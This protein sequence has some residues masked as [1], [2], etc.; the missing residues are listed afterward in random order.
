MAYE[1]KIQELED[2]YQLN[3]KISKALNTVRINSN[4]GFLDMG[5]IPQILG[6]FFDAEYC[7]IGYCSDNKYFIDSRQWIRCIER[8]RSERM[9]FLSGNEVTKIPIKGSLIGSI[10]SHAKYK[11]N[12]YAGSYEYLLN[13]LGF[14]MLNTN[15]YK[16]ALPTAQKKHLIVLGLYSHDFEGNRRLIGY[17]QL[18][19]KLFKLKVPNEIDITG[20]NEN[21]LT[22]LKTVT[23][24][25]EL[26]LDN[27]LKNE[28]LSDISKDEDFI[29]ELI[30]NDIN[31]PEL[32]YKKLL[33]HLTSEYSFA[34]ASFWF[35][36]WNGYE[37]SLVE[38]KKNR[39]DL[40]EKKNINHLNIILRSL[41]LNDNL[42]SDIPTD[43]LRKILK[44][45][46][47]VE[48][49][50]QHIFGERIVEEFI[51]NAN[52]DRRF[53]SF[54]I[55]NDED[56]VWYEYEKYIKADSAILI[57]IYR[58]NLAS[59][60]QSERDKAIHLMGVLYLKYHSDDLVR[61]IGSS[62]RLE[63][64]AKNLSI[65][66]EKIMFERRY[67]QINRLKD[68][69][70]D[71]TFYDVNVFFKKIVELVQINMNCE[72]C[73]LFLINTQEDN[74][75]L[76][77]STAQEFRIIKTKSIDFYQDNHITKKSD[78]KLIVPDTQESMVLS[79]IKLL[80]F[81]KD[82]HDGEGYE[83]LKAYQIGAVYKENPYKSLTLPILD[84]YT[85][86]N[87]DDSGETNPEY[88][89][90]V[91][92]EIPED[93]KRHQS[94][95]AVPLLKFEGNAITGVI[96]CIN[97]KND[98]TVLYSSFTQSDKDYLIMIAG[99]LSRF[100]DLARFNLRKQQQYSIIMHDF[101]SPL[102]V[103]EDNIDNIEKRMEIIKSH[104]SEI[105]VILNELENELEKMTTNLFE[106]ENKISI[107][108]LKKGIFNLYDKQSHVRKWLFAKSENITSSTEKSID[109]YLKSQR[110]LSNGLID[111]IKSMKDYLQDSDILG[112][113]VLVE[114]KKLPVK[115]TIGKIVSYYKLQSQYEKKIDIIC[116]IDR[117]PN[118]Y[119]DEKLF[120]RVIDNLVKNAVKYSLDYSGAI[121]IKYIG[122][123]QARFPDSNIFHWDIVEISNFG[124]PIAN[125]EKIF[126]Y[127]YREENAKK[128]DQTGSGI[129]LAAVKQCMKLMNGHVLLYRNQ[130]PVRF[131]LFFPSKRTQIQTK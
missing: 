75:E 8:E 63:I 114:I 113:S 126:E 7:A 47:K 89:D 42:N 52:E 32:I 73:S 48:K 33:K 55:K 4:S 59:Y 34:L 60:D 21:E 6:E 22:M 9:S 103:V 123:V 101:N 98:E 70:F 5:N 128:K 120:W 31:Q 39:K 23:T 66:F 131:R 58:T 106:S 107:S 26:T 40:Y 41:E 79:E 28:E 72:I 1:N 130:R 112:K 102:A 86:L 38:S 30:N 99:I 115:D 37:E 54:E 121:E 81:Q 104:D 117:M 25:I 122:T 85:C 36:F 61:S 13:N 57:P 16:R 78:F 65:V 94:Y 17:I 105:S 2:L 44:E 53:I 24:S 68:L 20:F 116:K 76:V 27:Y 51:K 43:E 56:K 93:R 90:H 100:I 69:L 11:E 49:L 111:S 87:F 82:K 46:K 97:K 35:P 18:I 3:T 80:N 108:K 124:I 119:I 29:R 62:K 64:F 10:L 118:L 96:R 129:G 15:A 45:C 77:A 110:E 67:R 50:E 14:N 74:L 71:L 12:G 91:F 19:N 109:V 125:P 83:S 88:S 127:G 92:Y 84:G 95:L